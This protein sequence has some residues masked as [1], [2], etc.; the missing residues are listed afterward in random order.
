[1]LSSHVGTHVD[2]PA[3]FIEQ[4]ATIEATCVHL[5]CGPC[6]VS[7]TFVHDA[8]TRKDLE[9]LTFSTSRVLLK[10]RN[11]SHAATAPFDPNFVYLAASGA[12]YLR[13]RGVRCV[14]IDY[15]GIERGQPD[16]ET[17]IILLSAGLPRH[18]SSMSE[19]GCA[20]IEGLRLGHVA[21]GEYRLICLPLALQ[22]LEAA[23]ARAILMSRAELAL[24]VW[25]IVSC[26]DTI[27][28]KTP[29]QPVLLPD[30]RVLSPIS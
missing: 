4:G 7:S 16:R 26:T 19:G 28:S 10:T 3:H 14:G 6:T 24:S 9:K 12:A 8:I 2:A 30:V 21:P 15:L 25:V 1:M 5:L 18:S 13:E 22:G 23:P 17:H 27:S 20:I 11:S 29:A